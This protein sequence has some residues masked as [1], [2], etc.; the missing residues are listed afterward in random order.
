M[1]LAGWHKPP[2]ICKV[3]VVVK[4]W[5]SIFHIK[6]C[7]VPVCSKLDSGQPCRAA[8]HLRADD[9]V[10]DVLAAL[11]DQFIVDV[12]ADEAVGEGSHGVAEDVPADGLDDVLDE[13]RTVGLDPL[14]FFRTAD[15]HVDDGF[16]AEAVLPDPGLDVGEHPAG[17]ELDEEHAA[18][19]EEADASDLCAF[20]AAEWP[21]VR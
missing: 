15:A 1:R 9:L 5:Y 6:L 4:L 18:F 14:P 3:A 21:L 10:V 20:C 12:A 11:D 2:L 13:L 19:A 17:G 7:F 16:S 8:A